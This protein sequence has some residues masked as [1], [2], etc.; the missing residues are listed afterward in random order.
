MVFCKKKQDADSYEISNIYDKDMNIINIKEAFKNYKIY[1]NK[2]TRKLIKK[3]KDIE[4]WL[5]RI[6][7]IDING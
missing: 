5:P 7:S 4:Y 1:N 6:L 3:T 2:K